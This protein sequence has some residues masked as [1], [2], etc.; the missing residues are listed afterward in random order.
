MMQRNGRKNLAVLVLATCL[1]ASLYFDVFIVR[2][3]NGGIL[4]WKGEEAYLFTGES[5]RGY[6]FSYFAYPFVLIAEYFYVVRFPNDEW[7]CSMVIHITPSNVERQ[8]GSCGGPHVL[9]PSFLT[10]FE[11]VFYAMCQGAIICKW[12]GHDY[13]P[14]TEEEQRRLGGY[15]GLVVAS[16]NDQLINGWRVHY[17]PVNGGHFD[18]H[19]SNDL[20][21]S[22]TNRAT[23][24]RAY[25]W[26]NVDL[27]RSGQSPQHL[28]DVDGT[29]RTV[30]KKEYESVLRNHSL[31]AVEP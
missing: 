5:H 22:V 20:V 1:A 30:S 29:P 16:Q 18:I 2:N 25:P 15:K 23:N 13:I 6:H 27:L 19:L 17:P 14:A 9:S 24:E 12:N 10:P 31:S 7:T 28:Y 26:I 3:D 11:G 4:Y 8:P 21:I